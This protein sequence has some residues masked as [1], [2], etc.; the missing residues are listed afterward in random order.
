MRGT[1]SPIFSKMMVLISTMIYLFIFFS[2]FL[3]TGDVYNK[4][5]HSYNLPECCGE[6]S[7]NSYK[8]WQ[9]STASLFGFISTEAQVLTK[10]NYASQ[11][12]NV[13]VQGFLLNSHGAI[14]ETSVCATALP[15]IYTEYDSAR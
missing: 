11:V 1:N 8:I 10:Q 13:I 3:F 9:N 7:E 14:N 4:L 2:H 5:Q 6:Y 15:Y 12:H